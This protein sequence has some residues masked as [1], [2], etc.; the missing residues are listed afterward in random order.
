ME[1]HLL[2]KFTVQNLID[3]SRD[4][5]QEWDVYAV[6]FYAILA[7]LAKAT[8]SHLCL[9]NELINLATDYLGSV[10][11]WPGIILF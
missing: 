6:D 9:K 8:H 4:T 3:P 7:V 11:L 1:Y 2:F 10:N 5:S